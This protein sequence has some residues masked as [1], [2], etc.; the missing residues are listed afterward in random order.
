M[1]SSLI[2]LVSSLAGQLGGQHRIRAGVAAGGIRQHSDLVAVEDVEQRPR[3][4]GVDAPHGDGGQLSAGCQQC[5]LHHL[6]AR[7]TTGAHDQPRMELLAGDDQPI[8]RAD[9]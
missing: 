4:G 2:Q 3:R 9:R 5:S 6:E 8:S 1:T 7:R